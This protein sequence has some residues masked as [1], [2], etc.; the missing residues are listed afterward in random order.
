MNSPATRT[1]ERLGKNHGLN[2]YRVQV[3]GQIFSG[4]TERLA[5][6]E[7]TIWLLEQFHTVTI[8]TTPPLEPKS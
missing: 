8:N 6:A 5:I 2:C 4:K 3:N 7:A 1:I